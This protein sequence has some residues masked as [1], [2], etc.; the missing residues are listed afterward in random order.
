MQSQLPW[1]TRE[2]DEI[3]TFLTVD[4]GAG[5]SAEEAVNRLNQYGPN[6]L[7]ER[8]LKS[9]ILIIWE[10]LTNPL[11]ILLIAAGVTSLLLGK[12]VDS[13]AVFAIVVVNAILGFIQEFR[14]EKAMAALKKLSSPSVRV[15]RAGVIVEIP[16]ENLVPGDILLVE[17]GNSIPADAR[18][19]ESANLRVQEASLTGESLPVDKRTVTLK[20]DSLPLGDRENMLYMGTAVTY[21]RGTAL[22]V[23]TGRATE[24]GRIADLI[25]NVKTEP[26][27]LQRRMAQLGRGLVMVV[28]VI[29]LL[30]FGSGVLIGEEPMQMFQV[31]V[32]MAV[33]AVPEGLPAVVTIVLALGAQR[34]LRRRALIRKLPAVETLGSVTTICSDKTGTLTE[35]R[36]TVTILDV[37][38]HTL[39]F[40]EE[41][42]Q[43]RPF[44]M[45]TDQPITTQ[46]PAHALLLAAGTLCNDA[47]IQ[48][49][50]ADEDEFRAIGDPTEGALVVAAA[51]VGLWK[52]RLESLF[53]RIAEVPFSSERRR[54]ATLNR[55]C[56]G[57]DFPIAPMEGPAA[58]VFQ[59]NSTVLFVK[60]GID[61]LLDVSTSIW[62]DGAVL[63]LTPDWRRRI[64]AAN[65]N[66]ARQGLRILG[67]AYRPFELPE[68]G[69]I[70]LTAEDEHNLILVGMVGM[71]DPPR[72]EVRTAVETCL[73]AGIRPVMITGDHPL[74]A[75]EIARMLKIAA[76]GTERVITGQELAGMSPD[77]LE[78]AVSEVSVY[79]RVSPEHKLNIVQA[80]Q[81]RGHVVA[82]TGDGVNDAPALRQSDIG[83]AMGITGTD[84]SKEAAGMIILDDN[85]ATIVSAVEEG[86]RVYENVRKFIRYTLGS[87]AG[88]ILVMFF[89][90][91]LGLPLPL[92]PL[93][94]L[95]M[96]LVTDGFPGLALTS[97]QPEKDFM[98]RPPVRP[99]ESVFARGL[100]A[101]IL[102]IGLVI[103]VVSLGFAYWTFSAGFNAWKTMVF[104]M[105]ILAQA[106]HAL[107]IR[108][109][110][111][112]VFKLDPRSN[113]SL[114]WAVLVT[115]LLQLGAV[116]LP[117]F[118][119]LFGTQPLS[120]VEFLITF[121]AGSSIL[122][123]VEIEK[124]LRRKSSA[125][126]SD[127]A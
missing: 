14:A 119:R 113:P 42:R 87:N 123:W 79:A 67:V 37:A 40:E 104:T 108:S 60:G 85:F 111:E 93:Q 22:V 89:A 56:G 36:M 127:K 77:D 90:P 18:V 103:G 11:V 97:E 27:P 125:G 107:A 6:E 101:Y 66:L 23:A 112:S 31:A 33:A 5:L 110:R 114:Y 96:N 78:R 51:R 82:M 76:P 13:L 92:T 1:H 58:R 75:L 126:R 4:S 10:Q 94:I 63:P 105:L 70:S 24:L 43:G 109:E 26:T 91:I 39:H 106:G 98:R 122:F 74:T 64:Q 68:N 62:L 81:K 59:E 116:Y 46:W 118:Q 69:I 52:E 121:A 102:R 47:V 65:E 83:V 53:P 44:L 25:Q 84:V 80:L 3:Q 73:T 61:S 95:W 35:N 86:R 45:H 17:A 48:R 41:I 20:G 71:M 100:A 7:A 21:G 99:D 117:P 49:V 34:M 115:V 72:A 12:V 50:G 16:T 55:C 29:V 120:L 19:I 88:E 38:D 54:M 124:W 28:L 9:P 2:I 15:R 32:S 8:G 57:A 30:A